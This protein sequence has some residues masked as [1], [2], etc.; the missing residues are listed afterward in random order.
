MK[1]GHQGLKRIWYATGYSLAGLRQAW[2]HESAFRQEITLALIMLPAGLWLG[3]TATQRALLCGSV[4]LVV[5][6]ELL[7]SAIEA[8]VDR[9]GPEK[10]EYAGRAK[11]MGSAAVFVSLVGVGLIWGLIA[12][13]R[14][15]L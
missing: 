8:A 6:V 12:W 1:P 10:H 2:A 11:D 3:Q 7:N 9:V 14:F 13:E 15:V 4:L 5:V